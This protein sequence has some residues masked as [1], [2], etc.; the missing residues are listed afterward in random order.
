M[1]LICNTFC[2]KYYK[3]TMKNNTNKYKSALL[4]SAFILSVLVLPISNYKALAL[5]TTTPTTKTTAHKK[6]VTKKKVVKKVAKKNIKTTPKVTIPIKTTDTPT[7]VLYY[8]SDVA[9][10]KSITDCWTTIGGKVYN[11]TPFIN[12]HPG[13]SS[14]ILSLC[15]KDGTAAFTKKHGGQAKPATELVSLLVG[16]LK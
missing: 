5:T 3:N 1:K 7:V 13:G 16:N 4:L 8:L 9:T 12:Q 15:G 2:I 6:V 11:L 10:H 14:A